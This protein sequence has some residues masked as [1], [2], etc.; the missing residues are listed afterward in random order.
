MMVLS[1]L[2]AFRAAVRHI[3]LDFCLRKQLADHHQIHI[4]VIHHED[5]RIRRLKAL[6]VRFAFTV[7]HPGGQRKRPQLLLINDILIQCND[8]L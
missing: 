7:P 6:T 5:V 2:Q 1:Q 4:I 3:N 8:K